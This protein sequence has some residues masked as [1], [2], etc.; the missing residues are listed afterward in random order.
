MKFL[1][2]LNS[3]TQDISTIILLIMTGLVLFQVLA[4]YV[5]LLPVAQTEE[6]ARYAMIWMA[7][8]GSANAIRSNTHIAVDLLCNKLPEKLK[9]CVKVFSYICIMS[10]CLILFYYGSILT[11]RSMMQMSPSMTW[12]KMGYITCVLPISG[13]LGILYCLEHIINTIKAKSEKLDVKAGE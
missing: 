6:L 12:L 5:L 7:L 10:F 11:K 13:G 2:K 1:N 9:K 3:A 8:I 4:R